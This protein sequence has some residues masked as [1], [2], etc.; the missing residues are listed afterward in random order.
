MTP[1]TGP[2]RLDGRNRE[3]GQIIVLFAL[4]MIAII[5]MAGML[6]DGGLAW[7]RQR[8]AQAAADTGALAAAQAASAGSTNHV[9]AARAIALS[10]G[11]EGDLHRL[12]RRDAAEP[13]RHHQS[14]TRDRAERRQQWFRRGHP[15]ATT[16]GWQA[17]S[18]YDIIHADQLTPVCPAHPKDMDWG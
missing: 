5:G 1:R 6:I 16:G 3:Q 10:N 2:R 14:P 13:G 12:R 9:T 11:F 7:S 8:Q 18:M 15:I 4:C 17:E